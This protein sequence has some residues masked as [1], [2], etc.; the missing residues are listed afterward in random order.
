MADAH[1]HA[2]PLDERAGTVCYQPTWITLPRD[3]RT[4]EGADEDKRCS[5]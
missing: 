5:P 4:L 2:Q 3:T 1:G